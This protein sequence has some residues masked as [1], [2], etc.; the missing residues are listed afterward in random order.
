M[1]TYNLRQSFLLAI[2]FI[3]C[4][5]SLYA[6]ENQTT[7]E[8]EQMTRDDLQEAQSSTQG[9]P[10]SSIQ[11]REVLDFSHQKTEACA[12]VFNLVVPYNS[13]NGQR[14]C[15]FDV[16]AT[17]AVTIQCFDANLYAGTTAN[18]EI[19]YRAGTHVGFE[20]NA[21]AWTFVGGPVSITSAGNNVPS[22]IP[23]AVGVIIPAGQRYSFYIT[24][25]FGGG[26]SYTDGTAVG[27]FLASDANITVYE[28]VGK[29]YPFGLTFNVR[30]FNGTI[31]YDPGSV[32]N[33]QAL[34]MSAIG[35]K[36]AIELNWG[37][38]DVSG[39]K[40]LM[41]E[42]MEE[43]SHA[44]ILQE[45]MAAGQAN[46]FDTAVEPGKNY[47]YRL[48]LDDPQGS[49]RYSSIVESRLSN[50]QVLE[51]GR[52]YP[53]PFDG[54]LMVGLNTFSETEA[55]F[56]VMDLQGKILKNW[57]ESLA[58]GRGR[59]ALDLGDLPTGVMILEV[60]AEGQRERVRVVKQ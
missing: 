31:F 49:T 2:T 50:G 1:N 11:D 41:I 53:N 15:M 27:N 23:I 56:R 24:N 12:S 21:A 32:L 6:Q 28:G 4:F 7:V 54:Q 36:D 39:N 8:S 3:F 26:T 22:A 37:A 5:T 14:G 38:V 18:Y 9:Q 46:W 45:K 16:F 10:I 43:G 30:N 25:D 20:N 48:R 35:G 13:N 33:G 19:Y 29:S 44:F 47:F 58:P 51:L 52:V 40:E 60:S 42:R 57:T 59:M 34:E 55:Q 17:N